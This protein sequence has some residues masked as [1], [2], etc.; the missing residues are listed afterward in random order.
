MCLDI[1]IVKK[2]GRV[3]E[4]I[5]EKVVVS[6]L[7]TGAD[8][9]TARK[10]VTIVEGKILESGKERITTREL[11]TKILRLLKNE[12]KEWYRNWIIFSRYIK[13]KKKELEKQLNKSLEEYLKRSK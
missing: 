12:N 6:L 8:L 9:K 10:I 13:K 5:P 3:E 2:D 7:R 11:M 4:F 1:K